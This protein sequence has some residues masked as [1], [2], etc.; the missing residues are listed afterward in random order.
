MA[1]HKRPAITDGGIGIQAARTPQ[2]TG[3]GSQRVQKPESTAQAR[4]DGDSGWQERAS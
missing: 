2:K 1:A 3:A 4:A